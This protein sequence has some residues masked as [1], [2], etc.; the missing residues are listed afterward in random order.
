MLYFV[1]NIPRRLSSSKHV[2]LILLALTMP[3]VQYRDYSIILDLW[4]GPTCHTFFGQRFCETGTMALVGLLLFMSPNKHPGSQ[5]TAPPALRF[6][7]SPVCYSPIMGI[8][9]ISKVFD[10]FVEALA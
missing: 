5:Q 4:P 7:Y 3:T 10:F 2:V 1:K 6:N 9:E 8:D